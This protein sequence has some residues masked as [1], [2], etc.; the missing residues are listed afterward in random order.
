MLFE[1][2]SLRSSFTH[3][4]LKKSYEIAKLFKSLNL[5]ILLSKNINLKFDIKKI[6]KKPLFMFPPFKLAKN[7]H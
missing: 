2:L 6:G 1:L 5:S 7:V 4:C 3:I